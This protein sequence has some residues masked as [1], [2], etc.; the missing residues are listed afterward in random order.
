MLEPTLRRNALRQ[1]ALMAIALLILSQLAERV[2]PALAVP[3]S[4]AATPFLW[5]IVVWSVVLAFHV[6]AFETSQMRD[7]ERLPLFVGAGVGVA[8]GLLTIVGVDGV[9]AS[10][11]FSFAMVNGFGAALFWWG[12]ASLALLV[13]RRLR[14]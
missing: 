6:V 1:W 2:R 9:S 12:A 8:V 13:L 3:R 10:S 14:G 11:R 4:I 5:A 7:L